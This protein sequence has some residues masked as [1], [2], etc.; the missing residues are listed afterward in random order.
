MEAADTAWILISAALVIFMVPGLA[1]VLRRHE[2][3]QEH[4]EH[5]D[6][7]HDLPWNCADSLVRCGL[8]PLLYGQQSVDRVIRRI[9]LG[10]H[11][12][13]RFEG[14]VLRLHVCVNHSSA[15]SWR[16]G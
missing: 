1:F 9:V 14:R 12:R 10:G 15:D 4:A 3:I 6:D 5:V 7:E 16:G 2:P 8:Q 11:Q 13:H